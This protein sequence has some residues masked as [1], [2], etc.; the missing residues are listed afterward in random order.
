MV[1][2]VENI[3]LMGEITLAG[4]KEEKI[5]LSYSNGYKK[6]RQ[7]FKGETAKKKREGGGE[8]RKTNMLENTLSI[9]RR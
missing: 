7:E 9:G 5:T 4:D 8:R 1:Q 2:A 6:K 3:W